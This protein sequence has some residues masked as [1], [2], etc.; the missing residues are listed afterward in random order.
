MADFT[1]DEFLIAV[2]EVDCPETG[3]SI[4]YEEV[5][6][7]AGPMGEASQV[8]LFANITRGGEMEEVGSPSNP[9]SVDGS[10]T[11]SDVNFDLSD[12]P[13]PGSGGGD[14]GPIG[15]G[16]G[17]LTYTVTMPSGAM[18]A[19]FV[20]ATQVPLGLPVGGHCS[21][22]FSGGVLTGTLVPWTGEPLPCPTSTSETPVEMPEGTYVVEARLYE[23]EG[24]E[25]AYCAAET[26]AFTG[27]AS[28]E[29][30][31]GACE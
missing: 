14:G 18:G 5:L 29:F 1:S 28:V 17:Q 9:I 10:D 24:E 2:E 15:E 11:Y 21:I 6:S 22:G 4:A 23:G 27:D 31:L 12:H 26:I 7:L 3:G 13:T 8:G 16:V 25:A 30:T 20:G 19:V